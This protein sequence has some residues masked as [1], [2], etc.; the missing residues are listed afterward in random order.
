[1]SVERNKPLN[2]HPRNLKSEEQAWLLSYSD[3]M[4]LL[5][6]FFILLMVFA[7]YDPK[8]F[9]NKVEQVAQHFDPK[10]IPEQQQKTQQLAQVITNKMGVNNQVSLKVQNDEIS[11]IFQGTFL[12]VDNTIQ[13]RP[14]ASKMLDTIIASLQDLDPNLNFLIEGHA[15]STPL[16]QTG[17]FQNHWQLSAARAAL[18][19]GRFEQLGLPLKNIRVL[20]LGS[21]SPLVKERDRKGNVIAENQALNRRVV[22]KVLA[23]SVRHQKMKLGLGAL[24]MESDETNSSP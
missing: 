18:V 22:I 2:R 8:E 3:L 24:F 19:A 12:F 7:D 9:Q 23:S 5:A 4:T 6:C 10:K 15:D 11:I 13:L 16:E 1:M 20:A 21:S 17:T 14:D